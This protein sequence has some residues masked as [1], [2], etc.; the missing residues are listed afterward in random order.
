MNYRL[1]TILARENHTSDI[2]KVIDLNL[3]DPVSQIIVIYEP[4]SASGVDP[5]AHPAKCISKIE[6][7]DGSDVL[8]S[9]SGTRAQAVDWYHR[10]QEPANICLY[11]NGNASEMVYILNFGRHLWD[12]LYAFDPKKFINPQLKITIDINGGGLLLD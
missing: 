5:V 2:T 9:L 3:S 12:P 1:A 8:F 6:L 4:L 10:K 7:I 11:L